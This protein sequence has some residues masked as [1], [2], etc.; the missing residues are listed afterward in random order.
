[1]N[2]EY[3]ETDKMPLN[4]LSNVKTVMQLRHKTFEGDYQR[5]ERMKRAKKKTSFSSDGAVNS[6]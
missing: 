6:W 2:S 4:I 1:M 3:K 5:G